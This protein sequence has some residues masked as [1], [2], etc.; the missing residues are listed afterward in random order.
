MGMPALVATSRA[1]CMALHGLTVVAT[2]PGNGAETISSSAA[3]TLFTPGEG[4]GGGGGGATVGG[5]AG[6]PA[7]RT[8]HWLKHDWTFEP[9]S[10]PGWPTAGQPQEP[11]PKLAWSA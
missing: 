3:C 2:R 11:V 9:A 6:G 4:G 5:H 8:S 10:G 7:Q 1:D